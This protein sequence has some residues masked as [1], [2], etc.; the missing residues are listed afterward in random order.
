MSEAEPVVLDGE[1]LTLEALARVA[2]GSP[3]ILDETARERMDETARWYRLG[4]APTV[5][6]EKWSQLVGGEPPAGEEELIRRFVV[7]H[8]AGVGDPLPRDLV[9]AAMAARANVLATATT[10]A[11]SRCVDVLLAMLEAD[12]VP[13]VPAQ[14][15]VGAAGDLAPL[16]HILQ[17]A[18][19]WGGQA[20]KDGDQVPAAEAMAGLPRMEPDQKEALSLING[21]TVT[22]AMAAVACVRARR[23][24]ET[25]EA[26]CALSF[27]VN[28]ADLGCL[29]ELA[30]GGRR[31]P[32]AIGVGAR[33]RDALA[34]SELVGHGRKPDP[35]SLRC[36]PAVL[37][38]AW[39]ALLYVEE[40]VTRELN[41]ACDNPLVFASAQ[42]IE[43]G[44]FHGAPVALAM[45]HLKVAL[46]QVASM[47]ERRTFR[48]TYGQLSGLP[49]FLLQDT[50]LNSGLM[51]AQYTA[52]SL[53]SECKG[54]SFPASVDTIP[55]I[56]HHEDHVSMGPI[57]ARGAL[58][59]LEALADVLAIELLC[60]AQGLDFHL[61]GKVVGPDRQVQ[62][63]PPRRGG[64]GTM[65]AYD[66]V[67]ARV[68][69]WVHDKA[70]YPDLKALGEAVRGGVFGLRVGPW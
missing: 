65:A 25:A 17:V 47:S 66:K 42:V 45:D 7:G 33:L 59:I 28:R 9:R 2:T 29:H 38:A 57:A 37:G 69:R 13:V 12:V 6:R 70:M 41:G 14:G 15:S 39:D 32:G 55:T 53:V 40:I 35:F 34:G 31:H 49:S 30:L 27:E 44:N 68:Q 24:M 51:L 64:A 67:R 22:A 18:C 54:L 23:L 50:G 21:A 5:L 3:A 46:T 48:M 63:V 16:A 8:C 19:G 52:A 43:A 20:Y 36:A 61:S 58:E 62:E 1:N 26:A 4:E 56:Q 11:R 60:G 10:A